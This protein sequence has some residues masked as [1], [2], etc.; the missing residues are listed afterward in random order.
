M[1]SHFQSA[2]IYNYI[3]FNKG[4]FPE[5]LFITYWL[6]LFEKTRKHKL[7]CTWGWDGDA[8]KLNF[9]SVLYVQMTVQ[10]R[11]SDPIDLI[12]YKS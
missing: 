2:F 1:L 10:R 5:T 9:L 8:I 11:F 12:D 6:L 3:T 4:I 7:L